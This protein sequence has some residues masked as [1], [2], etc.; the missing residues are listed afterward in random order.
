M[1]NVALNIHWY[2]FAVNKP[3]SIY[4]LKMSLMVGSIINLINQSD[5]F[6][7]YSCINWISVVMTYVVLYFVSSTVNTSHVKYYIDKFE[8]QHEKKL[9][10]ETKELSPVVA[11]LDTIAQTVS[12]N[13]INVNT[14]SKK[15][16]AFVEELAD[17]AHHASQTSERLV[18][19]AKKSTSSLAQ[20]DA[21]FCIVCGHITDLGKQVTDATT[22]THS[23][24]NEIHQFLNEFNSIAELARSITAISDQTNLLALNAAIEAARAGEAGRGFAVVADEVK[25]L[26]AQTKE[27]ATK[28]DNHLNVLGRHQATLDQA[29]SSLN[30]SMKQAQIATNS[31]ESSM[32]KSTSQVSEACVEVKASLDTVSEQLVEETARLN[33]MAAHVNELAE[34]TRNMITASASNMKVSARAKGLVN[35]LESYI[36][37]TLI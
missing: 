36:G 16:V 9:C 35:S 34:D 30:D 13:A 14:R 15:R 1:K 4:S 7:T 2:D 20:M 33:T 19:E 5:A 27:N 32:Q 31:S 25:S 11:E 37:K 12:Q 28:I 8:E 29:L 21:A 10:S 18:H 26:A 24:S 23:L 22:A 6:F 3:L 17:T